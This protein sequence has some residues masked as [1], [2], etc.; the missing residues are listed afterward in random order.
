[1]DAIISPYRSKAKQKA[2]LLIVDD[3]FC[4]VIAS[5]HF[6]YGYSSMILW[7]LCIIARIL[8]QS[9]WFSGPTILFFQENAGSILLLVW[10]NGLSLCFVIRPLDYLGFVS[11]ILVVLFLLETFTNLMQILPTVLKWCE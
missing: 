11:L 5:F 9:C 2:T 3:D 1:M 7:F 6:K 10:K 4:W 8:N